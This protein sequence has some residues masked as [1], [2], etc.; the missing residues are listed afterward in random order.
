M[1]FHLS[2]FDSS[3]VK[4]GRDRRLP[5][6][7]WLLFAA[8]AGALLH[9]V[10]ARATSDYQDW[11][12]NPALDGMG[13]NVGHQGDTVVVAWYHYAPGEYATFLLFYGPLINDAV[14]G[15]LWRSHGPVPGNGY[16]PAA[17]D[18]V[19]VG[20]A[21][22]QFQS[23]NRATFT[24]NYDGGSGV[25]NLQRFSFGQQDFSGIWQYSAV[26]ESDD[27][28]LPA[29]DGAFTDTG[30]LSASH[31]GT[32]LDLVESQLGGTTCTYRLITSQKGSYYEA[33]GTFSCSDGASGSV[34]VS[35]L[36]KLDHILS[37]K[38]DIETT[39]GETCRQSIRVGA[40]K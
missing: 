33:D 40:V 35:D 23:D 15:T 25:M 32:A 29:N 2:I 37:F 8:L 20:T 36:R 18:R 7:G 10:T 4:L 38:Y 27:C 6:Y 14:S 16:N 17:V 34:S 11:W 21:S 3:S 24:Y 26:G 28:T 30:V 13:F 9:T 31:Q 19:A 22:M 12:W 5:A 39:V 1:R